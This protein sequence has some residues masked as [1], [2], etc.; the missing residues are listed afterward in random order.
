MKLKQYH[1]VK[2]L[3]PSQPVF[4]VKMLAKLAVG[5]DGIEAMEMTPAGVLVQHETGL[6]LVGAA[7]ILSAQLEVQDE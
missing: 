6:Y 4:I 2:S 3:R 7:N 5:S 1:S